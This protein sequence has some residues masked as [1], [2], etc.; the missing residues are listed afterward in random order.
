ML[1]KRIKTKGP[2]TQDIRVRLERDVFVTLP[3]TLLAQLDEIVVKVA[4]LDRRA[5]HRTFN[6]KDKPT[7]KSYNIAFDAD[8]LLSVRGIE[9]RWLPVLTS[10]TAR[11]I[12]RSMKDGLVDVTEIE[13]DALAG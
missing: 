12:R 4:A 7:K 9:D 11:W 13:L 8:G 3:V 1:P 10:N 5:S 2:M 6:G